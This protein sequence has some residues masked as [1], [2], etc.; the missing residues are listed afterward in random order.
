MTDSPQQAP[1]WINR[2]E[3]L[4][5]MVG[6]LLSHKHIAVDT[7]SN[8]LYVYREQVCLMQFST[9]ETDYLVDPLAIHDLS[10]LAP[11]FADASIEKIFHAA[12]YDLSCLK[13]DFNFTFANI[14]DTMLAARILGRRNLGLASLLESEF[15][16]VV[17]KRFQRA[18][19]GKRPLSPEMLAY[20]R[21]D[22]YYLIPLRQRMYEDLK[23]KDRLPLAEEDFK[24]MCQVTVLQDNNGN[25]SCMPRISGS[26]DLGKKQEAVLWELYKYR[27]RLA[28]EADLPPFKILINQTLI[29][30]A[31]ACPKDERQLS[32]VQG[33]TRRLMHRHA[34]ELLKAVERGINGTAPQKNY[35]HRGK[36]DE[37][38]ISR[39]ENLR[40]WR[41]QSGRNL[42]VESDIILPRDIMEAIAAA[43]PQQLEGLQE[44][45]APIPWRFDRFGQDIMRVLQDRGF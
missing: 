24:L 38:Y 19:W 7:E 12:E 45:M 40:N 16:V 13:R 17:D 42:G 23:K 10:P 14:F 44:I 6:D 27:E 22:T 3:V 21:M 29:N 33:M 35:N 18:N 2:P 32:A 4:K 43:N 5:N 25:D 36:P 41:K 30:I 34:A 15:G 11:I 31:S 39:Y 28:K 26:Q 37:R 20:A 9:G 1:C 8:S